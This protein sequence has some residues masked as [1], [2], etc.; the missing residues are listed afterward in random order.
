MNRI[1]MEFVRYVLQ[2]NPQV[3]SFV[4]IY[5]AMS[6]TASARS[7]HNL[8][9]QELYIAGISFSLLDTGKLEHLITEARQSLPPQ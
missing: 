4:G 2:Q 8:G 9:Y 1:A 3:N 7:F 6:R 5:D